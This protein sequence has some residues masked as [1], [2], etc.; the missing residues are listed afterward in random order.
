MQS[1]D[2]P[3]V[4][5]SS[6]TRVQADAERSL[7][8]DSSGEL[9]TSSGTR[10]PTGRKMLKLERLDELNIISNDKKWLGRL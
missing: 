5:D 2:Q 10:L 4:R 8:R 9:R 6:E 1:G 7:R 3:E